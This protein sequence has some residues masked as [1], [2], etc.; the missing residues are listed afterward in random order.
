MRFA[1]IN[2]NLRSIDVSELDLK[3]FALDDRGRI[4]QRGC[5][6]NGGQVD[7]ILNHR[8]GERGKRQIAG[9][10]HDASGALRGRHQEG[11]GK[12][13]ETMEVRRRKMAS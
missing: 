6:R 3:A 10:G 11:G 13:E 12:E 1:K 5:I 9:F 2:A 8:F 4:R 7:D